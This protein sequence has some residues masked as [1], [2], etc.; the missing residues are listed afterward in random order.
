MFMCV[1]TEWWFVFNEQNVLP[2]SVSF[3]LGLVGCLR[4]NGV[5]LIMNKILLSHPED[6]NRYA[7]EM[8]AK[9]TKDN[10]PLETGGG[11]A[12]INT[13]N[14]AHTALYIYISLRKRRALVLV[15]TLIKTRQSDA[16]YLRSRHGHY[17]A[18][19]SCI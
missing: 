16:F 3:C 4:R 14:N 9:R 7:D 17:Y 2:H 15:I 11:C 6:K 1:H 5:A 13:E 10:S 19:V 12:L 8:S 18:Y